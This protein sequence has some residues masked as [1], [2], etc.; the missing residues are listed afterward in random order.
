V[1]EKEA[2]NRLCELLNEIEAAGYAVQ[3]S[4]NFGSGYHLSVGEG[5]VHLA[6]P[7]FDDGVWEVREQ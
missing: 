2:A 6:E 1:T 7:R 3:I 5:G 4:P